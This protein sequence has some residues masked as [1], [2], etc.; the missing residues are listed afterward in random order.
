MKYLIIKCTDLE[1]QY[2]C[3]ADREPICITD[4]YT[5]YKVY[6]YE[7]YEIKTDGSLEKIQNYYDYEWAEEPITD[8]PEKVKQAENIFAFID[9]L[10]ELEK[11][12]KK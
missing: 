4:D 5:D 7:V 3:D 12:L 1:D 11:N 6:G 9:E 2:E 10:L 8:D